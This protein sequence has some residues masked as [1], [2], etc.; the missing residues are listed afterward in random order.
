MAVCVCLSTFLLTNKLALYCECEWGSVTVGGVDGWR[1]SMR[2]VC[3]GLK[4]SFFISV[5]LQLMICH[6]CRSLVSSALHV[7]CCWLTLTTHHLPHVITSFAFS[8]SSSK[9]FVTAWS[10]TR[11]FCT[12]H[13]AVTFWRSV[14]AWRTRL[15]QSTVW[16][17]WRYSLNR[18]QPCF[19]FTHC[20]HIIYAHTHTHRLF[21]RTTG[22]FLGTTKV[23]PVTVGMEVW[24]PSSTALGMRC[25]GWCGGWTC[26]IWS[27]WTGMDFSCEDF[28]WFFKVSWNVC[29]SNL[30]WYQSGERDVRCL[31]PCGAVSEDQRSGD[32]LSHLHHEQLCLRASLTAVPAGKSALS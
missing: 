4:G 19:C 8:S 7:W 5:T 14:F 25:G 29:I 24:P 22:W 16:H 11:P 18:S 2:M 23:L 28:Y 13:M 12:L 31:Q 1:I 30:Q 20:K 27:H 15:Q 17:G 9:K 32:Q 3:G 6:L 10:I 26:L 21:S